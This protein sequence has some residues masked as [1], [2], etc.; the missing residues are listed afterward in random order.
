MSWNIQLKIDILKK[1]ISPCNRVPHY[2]F[3]IESQCVSADDCLHQLQRDVL[4]FITLENLEVRIC[5]N[6]FSHILGLAK[7]ILLVL[8]FCRGR[9]SSA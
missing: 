2:K 3:T 4:K 8:H 6:G 9:Q 5:G 7:L 1:W